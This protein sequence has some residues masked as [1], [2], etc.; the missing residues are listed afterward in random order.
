VFSQKLAL[1]TY[2]SQE[3]GASSCSIRSALFVLQPVTDWANH[4]PSQIRPI[5]ISSEFE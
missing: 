2:S 3:S 5:T 1:P 4:D